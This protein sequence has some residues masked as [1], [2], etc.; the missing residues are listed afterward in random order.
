M[1]STGMAKQGL[2]AEVPPG[3]VKQADKKILANDYDYALAA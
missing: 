1:A 2:Q 3:L